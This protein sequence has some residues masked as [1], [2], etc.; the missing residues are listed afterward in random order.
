MD[1]PVLLHKCSV[2]FGE[3]FHVSVY[4]GPV[5]ETSLGSNDIISMLE[6]ISTFS[7]ICFYFRRFCIYCSLDRYIHTQLQ[8]DYHSEDK[9]T[10]P[11]VF[12]PGKEV[13]NS[14]PPRP[15]FTTLMIIA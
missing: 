4:R 3:W 5:V 10:G 13:G 2:P 7:L 14:V 9:C 12:P 11:N 15:N 1:T 6:T 8:T